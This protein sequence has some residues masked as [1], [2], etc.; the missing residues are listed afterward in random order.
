METDDSAHYAAGLTLGQHMRRYL[1][2]QIAALTYL[3]APV[4]TNDEPLR[5]APE[6]VPLEPER[7]L[8]Q[9]AR[10]PNRCV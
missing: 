10:C 6:E 4:A 3:I 2:E 8:G 5:Q 9:E 1:R 7:I